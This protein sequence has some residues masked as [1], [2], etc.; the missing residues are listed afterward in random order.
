MGPSMG[1]RGFQSTV[2]LLFQLQTAI[3]CGPDLGGGLFRHVSPISEK[4]EI[5]LFSPASC[6][7]FQALACSD[8]N[9]QS[10]R[11]SAKALNYDRP[12]ECAREV[13]AIFFC[14]TR[15]SRYRNERAL[16]I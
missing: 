15:I 2:A 1:Q 5:V 6:V 12:Q 16:E 3:F 9:V 11:T 10:L 14:Q 7:R 13:T 4:W 8:E